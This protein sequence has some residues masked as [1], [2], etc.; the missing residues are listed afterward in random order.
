MTGGSAAT[1]KLKVFDK[2][3]NFICDIDNDDALLGSYP[4]DDGMRIHVIDNFTL[5]KDF[6]ESDS[7]ERYEKIMKTINFWC[8]INLT[9]IIIIYILYLK[10]I[11]MC[12][13]KNGIKT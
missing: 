2:K 11:T 9:I 3:N 12:K 10:Y 6:G 1:M 5:V 4:I 13:V 8:Y 7:A